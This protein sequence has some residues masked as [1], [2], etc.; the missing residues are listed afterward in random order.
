MKF[1]SSEVKKN[2][3]RV[4]FMKRRKSIQEVS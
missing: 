1:T 4:W 3:A 2:F